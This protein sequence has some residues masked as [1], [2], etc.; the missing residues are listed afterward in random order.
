M[1]DKLEL[2]QN[3]MYF[4]KN[5][6]NIENILNINLDNNLDTQIQKYLTGVNIEFESKKYSTLNDFDNLA[7]KYDEFCRV[8]K[9]IKNI[10]DEIYRLNNGKNSISIKKNCDEILDLNKLPKDFYRN[11]ESVGNYFPWNKNRLEGFIKF[12]KYLEENN[13]IIDKKWINDLFEN[14]LDK[15]GSDKWTKWTRLFLEQWN[16]TNGQIVKPVNELLLNMCNYQ[17]IDNSLYIY[18]NIK[19]RNLL[20]KIINLIIMDLKEIMESLENAIIFEDIVQIHGFDGIFRL[21]PEYNFDLVYK[22][23]SFYKNNC[24]DYLKKLHNIIIKIPDAKTWIITD[25]SMD[26]SNPLL[27]V[28]IE[29]STEN[30]GEKD[31]IKYKQN[32]QW[33]LSQ[34]KVIY[35]FGWNYWIKLIFASKSKGVG[36]SQ[37]TFDQGIEMGIESVCIYWFNQWIS[38]IEQNID[39][40]DFT[41]LL[42]L[43]TDLADLVDLNNETN[44]FESLCYL[45]EKKSFENY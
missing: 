26:S 18:Y 14:N 3:I 35:T 42:S 45:V 25:G 12:I 9:K 23:H 34:L 40:N 39:N 43:S 36:I 1:I 44:L 13:K 41:S 7:S 29:L 16:Q 6:S 33:S 17:L 21:F 8:M 38:V 30:K 27:N 10:D 15:E 4:D 5:A 31:D 2:K 32:M 28:I 24:C 22:I 37:L 11:L 19:E 20:V